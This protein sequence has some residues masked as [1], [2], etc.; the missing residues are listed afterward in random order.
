MAVGAI[1][2]VISDEFEF[3]FKQF[4]E[5][6]MLRIKSSEIEKIE[7]IINTMN[8]YNIKEMQKNCIMIY[9]KLNKLKVNE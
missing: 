3:P 6:F 2:I 5:N 7:N 9:D 4:G 8:I 1:P